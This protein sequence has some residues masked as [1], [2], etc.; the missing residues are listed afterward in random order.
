MGETNQKGELGEARVLADLMQ[1]G[2][3]V[4]IPF[5]HDV[6]FDLVVIRRETGNLERVQVKYTTSDRRSVRAVIRSS[7]AWVSR[8]YGPDEVDWIAVYDS[9]TDRCYYLPAREWQGRQD[10]T[11]RLAEPLN[12]QSSGIRWARDFRQLTGDPHAIPA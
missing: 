3:R 8:P 7:S 12:G 5:G 1:Q 9:T 11:L 6:P 4:A 2:H 10:L